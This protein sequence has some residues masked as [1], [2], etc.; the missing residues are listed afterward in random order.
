MEKLIFGWIP[1]DSKLGL[2]FQDA[3]RRGIE[4][5]EAMINDI[6]SRLGSSFKTND[7]KG[8]GTD[9]LLTRQG[10]ENAGVVNR[11]IGELEKRKIGCEKNGSNNLGGGFVRMRHGQPGGQRKATG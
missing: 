9:Y 8:L 4:G 6:N 5:E 7:M 11:Y 10:K 1:R 2:L 3:E